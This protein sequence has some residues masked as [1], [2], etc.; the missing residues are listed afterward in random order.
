MKDAHGQVSEQAKSLCLS[1][2]SG[3]SGVGLDSKG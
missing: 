3:N 2:R 1:Y